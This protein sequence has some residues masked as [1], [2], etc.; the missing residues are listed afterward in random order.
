MTSRA[1][2]KRVTGSR[3]PQNPL[4]AAPPA[5]PGCFGHQPSDADRPRPKPARHHERCH[6][7]YLEGTPASEERHRAQAMG[8][9]ALTVS[10]AQRFEEQIALH[11]D[12]RHGESG[13]QRLRDEPAG[14]WRPRCAGP[15]P[16]RAGCLKYCQSS[17]NSFCSHISL[18]CISI[19]TVKLTKSS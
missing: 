5:Q 11:A 9:A 6:N 2:L 1:E 14:A 19:A 16:T 15:V 4:Q 17:S 3:A 18:K 10:P 13:P 8:P 12:S 7:A